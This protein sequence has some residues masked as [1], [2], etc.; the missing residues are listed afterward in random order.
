MSFAECCFFTSDPDAPLL[1]P[2]LLSRPLATGGSNQLVTTG[3]RVAM[4]L[5]F[6]F[7][8]HFVVCFLFVCR[9]TDDSPLE[10]TV[11]VGESVSI[12]CPLS[13][14]GGSVQWLQDGTPIVLDLSATR[15]RQW[16][17]SPDGTA[18]LTISEV[19]RT[20]AGRWE[21]RE[22]GADGSVRKV[23]RVLDLIVG[24]SPSDP[25][26]ELEGRRLVHQ[27]TVTVREPQKLSLHCI[28]S[29]AIPPVRRIHWSI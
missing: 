15:R 29:G 13:T 26:L 24:S 17:I 10:K 21:C 20:D 2:L 14:P 16:N 7:R 4:K 6:L 9:G 23:A 12:P 18:A 25:Y 5:E 3:S 8:Q 1:H 28:V 19:R 11:L 27:A 22:L